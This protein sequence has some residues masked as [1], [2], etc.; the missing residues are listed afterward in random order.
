MSSRIESRG[1]TRKG[2]MAGFAIAAL[3]SLWVVVPSATA[4]SISPS[5]GFHEIRVNSQLGC[6]LVNNN[7][8]LQF[9]A[10]T[11]DFD[12]Y[13]GTFLVLDETIYGDDTANENV[14]SAYDEVSN[15]PVTGSGTSADPYKLTTV[16]KV[17]KA[18]QV[19]FAAAPAQDGVDS[20]LTITETETYVAGNDY[21]R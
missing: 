20:L 6:Q 8:Q 5:S 2:W 17:L 18:E 1:R 3:A 14:D 19:V 7:S 9:D 16:V 4:A 13:C 15:G 21:F 11:T 12:N 10:G